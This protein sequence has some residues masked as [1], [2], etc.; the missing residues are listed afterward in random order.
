MTEP[1]QAEVPFTIPVVEYVR[2]SGRKVRGGNVVPEE[3]MAPE[4]FAVL[5]A[6]LAEMDNEG[7]TITVEDVGNRQR[8]VCLDNGEFDYKYELFRFDEEY[9]K[10][11][12]ELVMNFDVHDY[13]KA[14][15]AYEDGEDM[16]GE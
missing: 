13:R 16:F 11:V 15:A 3:Y 6:K 8:N 9:D 5:E 2:P 14:M 1:R 10:K 7:I 12:A 4:K